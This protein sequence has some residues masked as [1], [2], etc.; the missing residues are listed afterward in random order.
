MFLTTLLQNIFQNSNLFKFKKVSRTDEQQNCF[1][2]HRSYQTGLKIKRV[3]ILLKLLPTSSGSQVN[4]NN[5]IIP[6]KKSNFLMES[7]PYKTTIRAKTGYGA[8]KVFHRNEL[9][10]LK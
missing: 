9:V 2:F 10:M 1:K 8:G 4:S 6:K 3:T 5:K 7:T